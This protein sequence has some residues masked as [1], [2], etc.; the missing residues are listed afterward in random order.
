MCFSKFPVLLVCVTSIFYCGCG[1]DGVMLSFDRP[2]ASVNVNRTPARIEGRVVTWQPKDLVVGKPNRLEIG[3][4]NPDDSQGDGTT[5]TLT[6][7]MADIHPAHLTGG[8]IT[9]GSMD[10]DP[11]PLN[12][13]S[14]TYEFDKG[15]VGTAEIMHTD[16]TSLGWTAVWE[17]N[18]V[19]IVP[20]DGEKLLNGTTY[21]IEMKFMAFNCLEDEA[22]ITFK[23]KE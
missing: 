6:A 3:W 2:P 11:E 1:N 15:V 4:K 17:G 14:V 16:G 19:M 8:S 5:I 20:G 22:N 13:A 18:R 9:H 7:V 21:V 12:T 10:V 23:T